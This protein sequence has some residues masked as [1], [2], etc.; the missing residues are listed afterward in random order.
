MT[1]SITLSAYSVVSRP[2]VALDGSKLDFFSL[3]FYV[4]RKYTDS[5]GLSPAKLKS[6]DQKASHVFQARTCAFKVW[7]CIHSYKLWSWIEEASPGPVQP[8]LGQL[9]LAV[10]H[11]WVG[12]YWRQRRYEH[13]HSGFQLSYWITTS[14]Y[15]SR[16]IPM[17]RK[18]WW[19][20][21][22]PS[23]MRLQRSICVTVT[24]PVTGWAS[25][26]G[27]Q[28]C[29]LRTSRYTCIVNRIIIVSAHYINYKKKRI[30][31]S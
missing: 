17:R 13:M 18:K 2:D 21:T 30:V 16:P 31:I 29:A 28:S 14:C 22:W 4:V 19:T 11:T 6:V 20:S 9:Q 3:N 23:T 1:V 12:K 27:V 26:S 10:L 5:C 15:R 7:A 8:C 25:Q 24:G